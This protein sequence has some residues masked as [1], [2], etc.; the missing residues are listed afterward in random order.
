M[1]I[2]TQI[3]VDLNRPGIQTVP[4]MQHDGQTRAVEVSLQCDGQPWQPPEGVTAAIGYEKPDRTRGLYDKLSDGTAAVTL[5]GSSATVVLAAQML[6]VPGTVRACL[7]FQDDSLNQL[8][9]FPFQIQVQVNPA[10]DAPQSQDYCR[11]QWLED[12][13]DE[14]LALAKE[15]GEFTGPSGPGPVLLGQEVAFQVSQDYRQIPTGQ[16]SEVL[17][18]CAPKE[19]VWSRTTAHYDSGDVVTY[20]VSRNGANGDGAISTICGIAP[21]DSG[22]ISLTAQDVGALP[23][24]GG[25]VQGQ[26]D[27]GSQTLTGLP[28]PTDDTDAAGKGYV[29][30]QAAAAVAA[31]KQAVQ[32]RFVSF[33]LGSEK[34]VGNSAPYTLF[35]PISNLE[36]D[37]LTRAYPLYYGDTEKDTAVREAIAAVSYAKRTDGGITFTCLEEKPAADIPVTVE[38]YV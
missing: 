20:S 33:L 4:A 27:M 3:S 23:C 1:Q 7:V 21:D 32:T 22:N 26:I 36:S 28:D 8:S 29:D 38:V 35:V 5:S 15:S 10:A 2:Q 24:V 9:T 11:L 6:S 25:T 37:L 16:W 13:L 17:P 12:K 19:Y 34:W 31:A 18:S 30:A 14:Y